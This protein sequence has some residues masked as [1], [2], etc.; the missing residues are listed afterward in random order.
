MTETTLQALPCTALYGV[1]AKLAAT[2]EKLGIY[3]IQDILFH[4]PY[5]YQDRTQVQSIRAIRLGEQVVIEGEIFH[6]ELSYGKRRALLVHLKDA[7]GI[8][9]LRFFYFNALQRKNLEKL[10][11]RLRC[12][13]EVRLGPAG[14]EMVHPEYKQLL[15]DAPY[16]VEEN[17][18]PIYPSTEGISQ[19]MWRKLTDA[20]L[21]YLKQG[22][23]LTEILPPNLLPEKHYPSL[24]EAILYLHRPPKAAA[25][26]ALQ[27]GQHP[28]Q[29]RLA[30]EELLAQQLSLLKLR[31]T[32]QKS[33]AVMFKKSLRLVPGL[34]EKLAFQLTRAQTKVLAEI[35]ED[36]SKSHPMLRLLQG[37]VGSGKT[38]VA[39]LAALQAIENNCQ[40]ALM[41]PTELL[42][43][44]H[45]ENFKHWLGQ[46]N[47]AVDFLAAK[48][49]G[50]KRQA[51]LEK[52]QSGATQMVIGTHALFQESVEFKN[53]ALVII[54]EQHRFGVHQRLSLRQK[55]R[56]ANYLPHQ[57]VM[58]ATPIPRTLAM[59]FYA[60]LAVSTLDELPP[61]RQP[62]QTIAISNQKRAEV[63]ARVYQNCKAGQQAYWVCPL[64]SES[65][66]LQCE[67]AEKTVVNLQQSLT[68]LR[69][70]LIHGRMKA[71]EK[72]AVMQAFKDHAIDLLVATTVIEVGVDV[73][74]ASLMILENAERLGLSQLHQLRGRVGRGAKLSHCVLLFQAPLSYDAK[75][76]IQ[77][78]RETQD[79]F[80]I[81]KKDLEIRGPG[82]VLGTRQTGLMKFRI[83]D[84][85]RDQKLLP[86]VQQTAQRILETKPDMVE[87]LISRWLAQKVN[88][89]QV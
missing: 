32:T 25:L 74:N 19:L 10:G 83:A 36:L 82:E 61:G 30:F 13:G 24:P 75:K 54:D 9:V 38:I 43:E 28:A 58:T 4:L 67:A 29:Q 3:N 14:L 26:K 59:T 69:I 56:Q 22:A 87:A 27:A 17:L 84:I 80:L 41:A 60:D 85:V 81:A 70:G 72:Q 40:V 89:G 86:M 73:P 35:T 55:G 88:Y 46:F 71:P 63:V 39:A 16:P 50:K 5:R 37:D 23:L 53:L 45:F 8:M 21:K 57:L 78:M 1:G 76:R 77:V 52:I 6:C 33:Q 2:L 42:A 47:L 7:S 48:I 68:D 12:F 11:S 62:I 66:L 34:L 65:E 31:K 15:L 44:Q 18:T 79:G 49:Q 51:V 20:A 64:I